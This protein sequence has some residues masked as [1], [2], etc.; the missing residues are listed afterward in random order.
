MPCWPSRGRQTANCPGHGRS[1]PG[2][3]AR[4]AASAT[5]ADSRCRKGNRWL[6]ARQCGQQR[7]VRVPRRRRGLTLTDRASSGG[8][9]PISLATHGDPALR[10]ERR[11]QRQ[12]AGP[13]R[14][15]RRGA[16]GDRGLVAA[17]EQR[18]RESGPDRPLAR[19]PASRRDGEGHESP[20][21]VYEV[22]SDGSL[23]GPVTTPS[24]GTTPFGF[25]FDNRGT[26]RGVG[27]IRRR[28]GRQRAV[29][30]YRVER[31][32]S[33]NLVSGSKATTQTAACW[34]AVSDNNHFAY[35]A[36]AGSA[37]IHGLFDRVRRLAQLGSTRASAASTGA[38]P[39][40]LAFQRG[41]PVP[42]RAQRDRPQHR[43]LRRE[44]EMAAS[45]RSRRRRG[46]VASS[47]GLA[48]RAEWVVTSWGGSTR[49]ATMSRVASTWRSL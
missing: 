29:S 1:A 18:R 30:S 42:L 48:A 16:G 34:I 37:S 46:L 26:P 6:F 7:R 17:A 45:S 8:V 20:L 13:P 44:R 27:G 21:S 24:S 38:G 23:T 28:R 9:R 14:Q 10:A 49:A 36:N 40:E 41:Q 35:A 11:R 25:G 12:R 5:R 33:V 22:S 47:N 15:L 43:R 19:W 31:D 32:G 2:V 4:A 39:S 3:S